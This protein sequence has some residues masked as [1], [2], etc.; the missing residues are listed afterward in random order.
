MR[1]NSMSSFHPLQFCQHLWLDVLAR[2]TVQILSR[3]NA[4]VKIRE[5]ASWRAQN[6][7]YLLNANRRLMVRDLKPHILSILRRFH[8]RAYSPWRNQECRPAATS[9]GWS[10]R[11]VGLIGSKSSSGTLWSLKGSRSQDKSKHKCLLS[12]MRRVQHS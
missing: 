7:A 11:T 10:R 12:R 1:T 4:N 2:K 6:V 8:L 5:S 9:L 3:C